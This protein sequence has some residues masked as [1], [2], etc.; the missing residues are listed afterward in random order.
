MTIQV[1]L[2]PETEAKLAKEAVVRGMEREAYA[3]KLLRE[4]LAPSRA[5][6]GK[7]TRD[8]LRRML[9]EVA[10]GSEKLPKLPTSAF[11]RESLSEERN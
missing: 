2:D 4:A 10:E 3:S 1:E 7:L 8:E 5:G 11:N 6:A 9:E